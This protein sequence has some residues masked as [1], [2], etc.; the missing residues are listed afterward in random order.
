MGP[1]TFLDAVGLMF[2]LFGLKK[3]AKIFC[4]VK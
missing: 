4:F 2:F 1:M 3:T